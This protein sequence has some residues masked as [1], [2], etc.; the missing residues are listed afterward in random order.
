MKLHCGYWRYFFSI[1]ALNGCYKFYCGN[2]LNPIHFIFWFISVIIVAIVSG[3]LF[4]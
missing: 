1:F 3:E 2:G 4:T